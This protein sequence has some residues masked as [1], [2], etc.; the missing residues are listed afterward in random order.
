MKFITGMAASVLLVIGA[1]VVAVMMLRSP[2]VTCAEVVEAVR[3]A[4]FMSCVIS[5]GATG[6]VPPVHMKILVNDQG[7]MQM[8]PQGD[9]GMRMVMDMK[10][11]RMMTLEPITKTA[12][13]MD[14]KNMPKRS[15]PAGMIDDFKQLQGKSATDLGRTEIDGRKAEKFIATQDGQEYVVWADPQTR[16]PIRVDMTVNQM[17]QKMTVSMTDFDFNPTVPGDAFSFEIPKGYTVQTLNLVLPDMDNGEQNIVD[18]LR[19]YAQKA[20][21]N[22]RRSWTIW[23]RI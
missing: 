23:L 13:V 22:S 3:N 10:A 6:K 17:D 14:L 19:G 11:G 9:K 16:E 18:L 15:N 2:D 7:Q 12:I 20:T 4:R 1:V 21:G 5:T 8:R